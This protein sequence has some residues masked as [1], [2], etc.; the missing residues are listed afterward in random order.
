MTLAFVFVNTEISSEG[1]VVR[2]LR[3]I[4]AVKEVHLVYG[5]YDMVAKVE[6]ETMENLKEIITHEVRKQDKVR[7]TL[8]LLA[9]E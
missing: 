2:S 7:S 1:E 6:A 8:T 4:E 3:K 9:V 5:V